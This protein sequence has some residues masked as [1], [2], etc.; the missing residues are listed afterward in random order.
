MAE[1]LTAFRFEVTLVHSRVTG[2]ASDA[3]VSVLGSGAFAECRGLEL[4][5]DV[6]E[7]LEGGRND[8]VIRR[9]GRVKLVPLILKRG[10]VAV[11]DHADPALWAWL[12]GMVAGR[13]PIPRYDGHVRV[14]A[15][16]NDRVLAHWSFDRGLPL[17]VVGPALDARAGEIAL[18]ELHIAHE[19]LRL[20]PPP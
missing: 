5:A 8:G 14:C 3:P 10:M 4:E 15:P 7:Y 18:E 17:K 16:T 19:G 6:R 2:E 9:V 13:L 20:E 12:Q 1:L 11:G